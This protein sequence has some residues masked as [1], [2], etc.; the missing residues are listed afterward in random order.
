MPD[1]Q[2]QQH[3]QRRGGRQR[4]GQLGGTLAGGPAGSI[5]VP[6]TVNSGGVLQPDAS[7]ASTALIGSSLTINAGGVFQ[8]VYNGPARQGTIALGSNTLNLPASGNP[9][10]RPQFS[11]A[12]RRWAPMS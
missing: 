6:V 12:A 1:A 11:L 9:V 3:A 7:Q 2:G 5:Q 10:F 4:A 8:W